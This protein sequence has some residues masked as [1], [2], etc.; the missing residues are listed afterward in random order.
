[1]S[2][3]D[4]NLANASGASFRSD[5]NNALAAILSNNSNASSPSTTAA[6]MIWVDTNANKLKIRNSANDAWVDLINLD[7]TIV[8]DLQLTGAS[9]NIIFDQS[10]SKLQFYDNARAAFGTG[11]DLQIS[12]DG[13]NSIINDAGTG[14]LLLQ[15]AGNTILSLDGTGVTV[16]DPDGTTFVKI[17]G[18]EGNNA[19]LTLIADEG[20]DNGDTWTL[21]S[22][23]SNNNFEILNDINGSAVEK[24]S[25]TTAGNVGIGTTTPD[26]KL[27]VNGSGTTIMK[28][29][30][31]DDGTAQLTLANS[32]S[33]NFN[34][35]QVGGNTIFNI[36][37]G[38]RMRLTQ[39]GDLLI[40][41]T[42]TT[43]N[44]TNYGI[45]L[46]ADGKFALGSDRNQGNTIAI[47]HGNLGLARIKGDGDLENTNNRY[48]AL[49][50]QELK[51][52]I[53]DAN[54]Q[55]NDIKALKVRNYNFKESTGYST[56]KQIGVVAQELEASGINGLVKNMDDEL[57]T[58]TDVLPEGKSIGDVKEK[59]YKS[60]A[61]S[62][63]YMKAIKAL[64]EAMAKIETLETKVAALEA[65]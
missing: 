7:G 21:Q 13:T 29:N 17:K 59:G 60:V 34:L 28:V 23:H 8:R 63:L 49:S 10:T 1:M 42:S 54:S 47:F 25:I 46:L 61:Y 37:G 32:G 64:Q 31:T 55:W 24:F 58:E 50:D 12:H 30:N 51:E 19:K 20:D 9:A 39:T 18:F 43:I 15:R 16:T 53:V 44:T 27:V 52:N 45:N 62:V 35:Q 38:E 4:Y 11:S 5:L 2:T 26:Q 6:Y 14:E 33:S 57:Y 41:T 36:A 3:H 22:T 48:G 56:H 40:G 65:A